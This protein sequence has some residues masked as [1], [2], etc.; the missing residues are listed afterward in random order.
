MKKTSP[1]KCEFSIFISIS[2]MLAREDLTRWGG[3]DQNRVI[4][5]YDLSDNLSFKFP[6]PNL[7]ISGIKSPKSD[8]DAPEGLPSRE[9]SI[10]EPNVNSIITDR[11]LPQ[12]FSHLKNDRKDIRSK[13][14][15]FTIKIKK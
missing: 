4:Q 6:P 11:P 9:R 7:N 10:S 13:L 3:K 5:K 15:F 2:S 12:D 8:R 1:S 14:I